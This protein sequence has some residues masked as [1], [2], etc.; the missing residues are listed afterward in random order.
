M[1]RTDHT[2]AAL[3]QRLRSLMRT[4]GNRVSGFPANFFSP[5]QRPRGRPPAIVRQLHA[6]R[7]VPRLPRRAQGT[8]P[9]RRTATTSRRGRAA[10]SMTS[11]PA[12][13]LEIFSPLPIEATQSPDSAHTADVTQSR[14]SPQQPG[15]T[16]AP[17]SPQPAAT[18]TQAP[19]GLGPL[20]LDALEVAPRASRASPLSPTSAERAVVEIFADVSRETVLEY[21][22]RSI[23]HNTKVY[24]TIGIESRQDVLRAGLD[25]M[26]SS[27]FA[28]T[29]QERAPLSCKD[30]RDIRLSIEAPF[31]DATI[32]FWNNLLFQQDVI[33]LVKEELYA[34]ANIRFL[35]SGVNMCPRQ[36]ALGLNR[37]CLAFDAVKVVDAPCSRKASHL[38]MFIYKS[39]YSG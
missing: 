19:E 5:V 12:T 6:L 37:F 27:P 22:G 20:S 24:R 38:R 29:F 39:T 8:V 16:R 14:V 23:H 21:D 36:R 32:V 17:G 18:A 28:M 9:G 25:A 4:Q 2:P 34:M 30:V 33:E 31:A 7:A 26:N 1:R 13:T 35:M 15:S 10:P 3:K 11:S